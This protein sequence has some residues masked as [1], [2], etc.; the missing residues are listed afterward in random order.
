MLHDVRWLV[1][2]A[3]LVGCGRDRVVD[4]D[5]VFYDWS[6]R[7][8]LCG[9][10]IDNKLDVGL[11]DLREGMERARDRGEALILY[12]HRIEPGGVEADRLEAI[13]QLGQEVGLP[14]LTFPELHQAPPANRAGLVVTFDDAYIENWHSQRD[15]FAAYGARVTFF[16]TRFPRQSDTNVERL[17]DLY[18]DGHAIESHGAEHF[19]G[20][21]YAEELG[22]QA[23]V[24]TVVVPS[25]DSMREHGFAPTTFAY[26]YGARTGELDD[27]ILEHVDLVRSISWLFARNG[28]LQDPCPE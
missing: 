5:E 4:T 16:V 12:G 21:E 19:N 23:Y 13:L 11:D 2:L 10:G 3:V 22:V 24:D 15:L 14:F 20:P 6:A 1:V 28:L 25:L 18:A 8:V 7:R 26:P 17:H 9:V 27:A